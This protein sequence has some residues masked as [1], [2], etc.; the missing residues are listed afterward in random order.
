MLV[1]F[2]P[3][4][5][6]S[7]VHLNLV[8]EVAD[9]AHDGLILHVLHVLQRDDVQVAGAGDVDIAAA[10]RIFHRGHLEAFHGG[11]QS[12]DGIDLGDHH[13]RAHAPQ[14]MRRALAHI[15]I[16]ADHGDLAGHHHVGGALDAVRQ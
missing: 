12:V 5:A 6:F 14:R 2:T 11:L 16:T 4:A 3:L 9:V 15:A 13:A 7:G 8:I 1:R 10:E